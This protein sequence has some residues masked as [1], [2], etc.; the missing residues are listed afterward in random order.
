MSNHDSN[1]SQS[2]PDYY[3][4]GVSS[5]STSPGP[6]EQFLTTLFRRRGRF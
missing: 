5:P 4:P 2:E 6:V 1:R 3:L